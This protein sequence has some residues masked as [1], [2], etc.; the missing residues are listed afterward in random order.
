MNI[1]TAVMRFAGLMV[2]LSALLV[3]FFGNVW[4]LLTLFVGLNMLQAT[5]TRFCPLVFLLK[6][7]GV[8]AGMVFD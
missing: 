7:A 4:L 2:L 1:D 6:K 5:F 8:K 3:Y